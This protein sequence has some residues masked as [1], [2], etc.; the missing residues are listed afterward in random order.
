MQNEAALRHAH[1][2]AQIAVPVYEQY[3]GPMG[4]L[5]TA[6]R[7]ALAAEDLLRT[8]SADQ[9]AKA[10]YGFDDPARER[11]FIAPTIQSGVPLHELASEQQRLAHR[12]LAT[13]LSFSGYARTVAHMSH[14]NVLDASEGWNLPD[15]VFL[16]YPGL[17]NHARGRDLMMYF[18]SIF[19][20]PGAQMWGWR[21][22]GH[23]VCLNYTIVQGEVVGPA[24]MFFGANPAAVP[25]GP[26]STLRLLGPEEDL[27]RELLATLDDGQRD[28]AVISDVAPFDVTQLGNSRVTAGT[29]SNHRL[30]WGYEVPE[31][32]HVGLEQYMDEYMGK[33]GWT[34]A[35]AAAIRFPA[36]PVGLPASRMTKDQRELLDQ[37][38]AQYLSRMPDALRDGEERRLA[39]RGRDNLHFAWAGRDELRHCYWRLHGAGLAIE[40]D[41]VQRDA[42]HAHTVWRQ[43]EDDFGASLLAQHYATYDH[44]TE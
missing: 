3:D 26:S 13:G 22:G 28:L 29:L 33:L 5:L 34:A 39:A 17:A 31:S 9:R 21:L 24:P 6:E 15:G 37:L 1:G 4:G 12:F 41:N 27:G 36:D 11:W 20:E 7:M 18:V 19:G 23:H 43:V 2:L 10:V 42:N 38:L 8:L 16:D 14:E 40:Y 25:W 35:H 30:L 44:Q 32:Q